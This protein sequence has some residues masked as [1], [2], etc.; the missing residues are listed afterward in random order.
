MPLIPLIGSPLLARTY[1]PFQS[2]SV[3]MRRVRRS[4]RHPAIC[5][6]AQVAPNG[7][8]AEALPVRP[9]TSQ[10]SDIWV[11]TSWSSTTNR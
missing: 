10:E 9:S 5:S 6:T 8:V 7:Q 4:S 2:R 3:V 1:W 11:G